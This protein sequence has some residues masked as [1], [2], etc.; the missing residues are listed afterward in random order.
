[1]KCTKRLRPEVEIAGPKEI[2]KIRN[3]LIETDFKH[4][5]STS[6]VKYKKLSSTP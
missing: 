3:K 2:S 4:S 1:L 6:I 5:K